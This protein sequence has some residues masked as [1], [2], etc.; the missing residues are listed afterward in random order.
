MPTLFTK[1]GKGVLATLLLAVPSAGPVSAQTQFPLV[2]RWVLESPTRVAADI[3]RAPCRCASRSCERW[4][5]V[6]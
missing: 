4:N 6:Q 1:A 3:P 2:G 5:A